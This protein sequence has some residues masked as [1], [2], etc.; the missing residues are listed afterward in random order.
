MQLRFLN[1]DAE[2]LLLSADGGVRVYDV[3]RGA[4][5]CALET[6]AAA[7]AYTE[8]CAG[9]EAARNRLYLA[10]GGHGFCLDMGGWTRLATIPNLWCYLPE[11]NELLVDA[12]GGGLCALPALDAGA[13]AEQGRALAGE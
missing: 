10:V 4:C 2:L 8:V 11:T 6:G 9:V 13:L 12:P 5:A 3:E 1:A 7:T